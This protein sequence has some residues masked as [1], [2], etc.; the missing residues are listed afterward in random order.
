MVMSKELNLS[1]RIAEICSYYFEHPELN[2]TELSQHFNVSVQR[3]SQIMSHPK[4]LAAYPVLAKRRI[5]SMV[6]RAI[7][8]MSELMNQNNNLNVAEKVASRILDSEKV[9][10]PSTHKIIH[11]IQTKSVKELHDIIEACKSIPQPVIEAEIVADVPLN[12]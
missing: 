2:Y 3:I 10:E 12:E 8:R 1:P 5:K 11:E 4:V 6:P 9:L 7:S